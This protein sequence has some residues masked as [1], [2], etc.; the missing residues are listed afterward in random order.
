MVIASLYVVINQ[1][2]YLNYQNVV[3]LLT[4]CWIDIPKPSTARYTSHLL[5]VLPVYPEQDSLKR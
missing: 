2:K 3:Q 5:R 4:L 1:I